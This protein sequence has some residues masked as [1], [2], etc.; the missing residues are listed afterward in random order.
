MGN[1]QIKRKHA[2]SEPRP[3]KAQITTG[4][5]RQF[6]IVPWANPFFGKLYLIHLV[7]TNATAAAL[8][9]KIW[10][11]HVGH[12][13]MNAAK[14]GDNANNNLQFDVPAHTQ[15]EVDLDE[16]YQAGIAM[17]SAGTVQVYADMEVVGN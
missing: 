7:I 13:P 3:W 15:I 11:E 14:R 6:Y 16:F 12:A 5:D 9:V 17:T 10:D 1:Q 4:A 8:L 2:F